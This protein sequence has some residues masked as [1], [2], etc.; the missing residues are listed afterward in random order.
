[1]RYLGILCVIPTDDAL[2]RGLQ[3]EL[4]N[5][6]LVAVLLRLSAKPT[7][8]LRLSLEELWVMA[9]GTQFYRKKGNVSIAF[10]FFVVMSGRCLLSTF[11]MYSSVFCN[12]L[13]VIPA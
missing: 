3:S 8:P 12:T 9:S 4:G 11:L 1:M 7:V 5:S 10:I 6:A 2:E 13:K